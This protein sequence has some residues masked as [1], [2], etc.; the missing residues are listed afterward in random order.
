MGYCLL[1]FMPSHL[2][3][4]GTHKHTYTHKHLFA[5]FRCTRGAAAV[6]THQRHHPYGILHS[7]CKFRPAPP[8]SLTMN[9]KTS[10][11]AAIQFA[12]SHRHLYGTWLLARAYHILESNCIPRAINESNQ[13]FSL[14]FWVTM[15]S[16]LSICNQAIN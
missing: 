16:M 2:L 14:C 13:G 10:R 5:F 4:L 3:L 7:A 11:A 6:V 9:H 8:N 1:I 15:A 12:S